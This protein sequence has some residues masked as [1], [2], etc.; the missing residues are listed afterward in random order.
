MEVKENSQAY[1][2]KVSP[3]EIGVLILILGTLPLLLMD[4][5][6]NPIFEDDAFFYW[7]SAIR[8]VESGFPTFDGY[9]P[10]NGF[11]WLWY[12]IVTFT[13]LIISQ[14]GISTLTVKACFLLVPSLI[15]WGIIFKG[16]FIGILPLALISA[17]FVGF[18]METALA[19][20]FLGLS[21][22]KLLNK[23]S[24][25]PWLTLAMLV[26]IDLISAAICLLPLLKKREVLFLFCG[27]FLAVLS[28]M[29]INYILVGELFTVSSQIK[30]LNTPKTLSK[31]FANVIE[32]ASSYGNIFRYFLS[33]SLSLGAIYLYFKCYREKIKFII[34]EIVLIS[35]NS[36]LFLHSLISSMRDWYFA[37]T[38]IALLIIVSYMAFGVPEQKKKLTWPYFSLAFIGMSLICLYSIKFYSSWNSTRVFHEDACASL[39]NERV[40]VFDGSGSLAWNLYDCGTVT[41]GDGLVNSHN[42]AREVRGRKRYVQYIK[43]N[44]ISLYIVNTFDIPDNCL[45]R[46]VCI[47][48]DNIKVLARAK[49]GSYY[50]SYRLVRILDLDKL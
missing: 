43:E 18:S 44:N 4:V 31:I 35:A 22:T 40:F 49:T 50:S 13:A 32:N 17:L 2:N 28:S 10:T 25:V 30:A 6:P 47:D 9:E 15:V 48:P 33:F 39:V 45:L 8:T 27:I 16:L 7:V 5:V 19:G 34:F 37:P 24:P 20:L 36:F 12:F 46:D 42:Y 41:N 29:V 23:R 38:I 26:R 1:P 14:L 21:L 11:H 3:M